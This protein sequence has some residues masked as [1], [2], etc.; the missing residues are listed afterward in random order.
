[1]VF[2]PLWV[3]KARRGGP[4][5]NILSPVSP[6]DSPCDWRNR[7]RL[8]LLGPIP[9]WHFWGSPR[10]ECSAS[11][12]W[13]FQCTPNVGDCAQPLGL[14]MG[15]QPLAVLS[16]VSVLPLQL[17]QSIPT[18]LKSGPPLL[19]ACQPRSPSSTLPESQAA[20]I[21]AG[22][23]TLSGVFRPGRTQEKI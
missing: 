16:A 20:G 17:P 15:T 2:S 1:M 3:H 5:M 8:F 10:I 9:H 19:V 13:E 18:F 21:R 6:R 22:N 23:S 7:S 4:K 14:P 12:P 11:L